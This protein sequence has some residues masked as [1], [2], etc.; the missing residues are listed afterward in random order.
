MKR[1]NITNQEKPLNMGSPAQPLDNKPVIDN[2]VTMAEAYQLA[3]EIKFN[4]LNNADK[5]FFLANQSR[6]DSSF[7][8]SFIKEVVSLAEEMFETQ[9]IPL[10]KNEI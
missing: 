6:I 7:V 8:N 4:K 3:Y 10:T 5:T 9:K 1:P 2:K